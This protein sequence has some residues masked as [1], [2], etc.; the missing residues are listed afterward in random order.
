M[1]GGNATAGVIGGFIAST[2]E[3][4][5]IGNFTIEEFKKM[6]RKVIV[7]YLTEKFG[8]VISICCLHHMVEQIEDIYTYLVN[9]EKV[10]TIE[11]SRIDG[12]ILLEST[13]TIEVYAKMI[14]GKQYHRYVRELLVLSQRDDFQV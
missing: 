5:V 12:S 13:I 14:K 1:Q 2:R 10:I 6:E 3:N 7:P 4:K 9:G 8:L 11:I